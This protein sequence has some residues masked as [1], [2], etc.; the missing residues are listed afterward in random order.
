MS[1]MSVFQLDS[2]WHY[3]DLNQD[4]DFNLDDNIAL[5]SSK[6]CQ[7]IQHF[8]LS[9]FHKDVQA[10]SKR[11]KVKRLKSTTPNQLKLGDF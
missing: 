8:D 3:Q 9:T 6:I 11:K 1:L 7:Q 10:N 4:K 5:S 2:F